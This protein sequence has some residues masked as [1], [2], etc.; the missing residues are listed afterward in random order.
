M[1]VTSPLVLALAVVT[2]ACDQLLPDR[3]PAV[4]VA[5]PSADSAK[6]KSPAAARP[7]RRD[8]PAGAAEAANEGEAF[9]Q[10]RRGLRRL[11]TAEQGFYA[12]NGAV[13]PS[14]ALTRAARAAI[15]A[16]APAPAGPPLV[17]FGSDLSR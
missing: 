10:L 1:R 12:E 6:P 16:G 8:P 14:A 4:A 7:R 15:A 9:S 11:V 3:A 17:L 5:P 2:V 13:D